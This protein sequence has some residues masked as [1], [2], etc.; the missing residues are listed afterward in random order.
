MSADKLI[1][2]RRSLLADPVAALSAKVAEFLGQRSVQDKSLTGLAISTESLGDAQA[3]TLTSAYNNIESTL[4]AIGKDSSLALEG[5]QVEAATMAAMLG[6]DPLAAVQSKFRPLPDNSVVMGAGVPDARPERGY[7]LE[8]YDERENRNSQL[9]SVIFNLLA[10][11]QDPFGETLFPTI[12]VSPNEQ[13]VTMAMKLFYVFNDFKRSATGALANY[14]RKNIIRAYADTTILKNDLT[15]GV[16]VLRTGGADDNTAQ[17]VAVTDVPSWSENLGVGVTVPTGALK[18]DQKVDL[19]G[20]SQTN[21]L[22]QSGVMGPTDSLDTYVRLDKLFVKVTDGTDTDVFELDVSSLPGATFTYAPQGNYRRMILS[23]DTDSIVMSPSSTKLNGQPLA[24]LDELATHKARLSLNIAGSASLDKGEGVV[25]RGQLSLTTLR[26][27][28]GVLVTGSV[29]TALADKIADCEVVGYTLKYFRANS[30]LRQRGQ[31]VDNQ[32]EYRVVPVNF[33]SPLSILAPTSRDSAED[34]SAIQTL[35]MGTGIR[36]SNEAVNAVRSFITT[37]RAYKDVADASGNL[38]EMNAIGHFLVKPVFFEEN[39]ELDKT[40]NTFRSQDKFKDIR[41]ALVEKIR[42][43]AN[44]M[45]R[46]AEYGPALNVMSGNTNAKPTVIIATDQVLHNYLL[47]D[48]DI[49]TL[50]ESFDVKIVSTIADGMANQILITFGVFDATR[51]TAI[52]PLNF[53]NMLYSP[54][55][56]VNLPINRDGQTSKELMV[57]PRFAHNVNLP[58]A[59]LLNVTGLPAVL[60]KTAINNHPV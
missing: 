40:V 16:P 59:T 41:A 36:I 17:F 44:E 7:A 49:R 42:W 25:N 8:A 33:R 19:I 58:V 60:T 32:T 27:A 48:G 15:R 2:S 53:G 22:L 21:E 38:P 12:I 10:P 20:I 3:Q 30:N 43:Y 54:E 14:A 45:Y 5:F 24:V 37:M 11:K 50:G 18:V 29:F 55:V 56:V 1:G 39:V 31:L 23:L 4:T 26:N 9:H 47:A 13:G 51:N 46:K 57:S 34:A 52:N 28:A 35:I 6:A